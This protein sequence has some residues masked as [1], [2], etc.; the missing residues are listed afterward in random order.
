MGSGPGAAVYG[1]V[2]VP[3]SP[4]IFNARHFTVEQGLPDRY[5][6]TVGQDKTGFV[7]IG[8]LD[9]AYRFDGQRFHALP[10][11]ANT[12][13]NKRYS[14]EVSSILHDPASNLWLIDNLNSEYSK[15][16]ILP[17]G[18]TNPVPAETAFDQPWL[19]G[20]DPISAFVEKDGQSFRYLLTRGGRIIHSTKEGRFVSIGRY[21]QPGPP[22][23][24]LG[25]LE[26]PH[27][28]LLL[29]VA[30]PQ[31]PNRSTLLVVNTRGQ[32]IRR[33]V[34][35]HRLKPVWAGP[36]GT[37]YLQASVGRSEATA[38]PRLTAHQL[39]D[40]LFRLAPDG[41]LSSLPIPVAASLFPNVD[42]ALL[43]ETHARYDPYRKLF[44]ISGMSTC[45]AWHPAHGIVFDLRKTDLFTNSLQQFRAAFIDRTGV[46]WFGTDDGV[47]M[48]TIEADRFKRYFYEANPKFDAARSS[49][50]GMVQQ[51]NRLW[52][53][54]ATSE[55]LDLKTGY[56]E[57]VVPETD[58]VRRHLNGL[59]PA[60][61]TKQGDIFGASLHLVHRNGATKQIIIYPF[62]RNGINNF[63]TALWHDGRHRILIG[64]EYGL[65]VFDTRQK[66]VR[67]F[68]RYNQF[69]ELA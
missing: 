13:K 61:G 69:N 65:S 47:V 23:A 46:V 10:V 42:P 49:I 16:L 2:S 27:G 43:R 17:S 56:S 66:K 53:N 14:P 40:F 58:S 39:T 21:A 55:W 25:Q 57:P 11:D 41:T 59:Y 18:S 36:D 22:V 45:F 20:A 68:S 26:T 4:F 6:F 30:T 54:T 12:P 24:L 19:F 48:L 44:W 9:N 67:A 28:Q 1:Q 62:A 31:T 29:S 3:K 51:G 7:W 38:Q 33:Q 52:V 50:R 60:L 63:G 8:T 32:V 37:V 34:L 15:L 35:P 64:H 5:V